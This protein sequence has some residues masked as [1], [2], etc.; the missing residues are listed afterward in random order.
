MTLGGF[1]WA[2]LSSFCYC[3]LGERVSQQFNIFDDELRRCRWYLYP[4]EM[5]KM[6]LII[7]SSTQQPPAIQGYANTV[8]TRDAF[9]RVRFVIFFQHV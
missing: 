1:V 7:L 5:Q 6:L 8:C 3:E 9:K 2:L 4:L